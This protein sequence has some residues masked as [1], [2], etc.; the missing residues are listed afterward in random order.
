MRPLDR[1]YFN[2]LA[3]GLN[4]NG[5]DANGLDAKGLDANGFDAKKNWFV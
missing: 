1:L 5:L 3:Y 4:L 2:G